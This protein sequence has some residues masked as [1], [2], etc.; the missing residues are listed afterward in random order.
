MGKMRCVRGAMGTVAALLL[1]LAACGAAD[2]SGSAP[3]LDSERPPTTWTPM[4][5]EAA[6]DSGVAAED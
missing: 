1:A 5:D 6:V 2:A 3:P 4:P